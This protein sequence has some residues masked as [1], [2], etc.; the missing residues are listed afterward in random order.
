MVVE[1][2]LAGSWL[3]SCPDIRNEV[4]IVGI[5]ITHEL[6]IGRADACITGTTDVILHAP[7]RDTPPEDVLS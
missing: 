5:G 4:A 6:G 3:T 7:H 2:C 1:R